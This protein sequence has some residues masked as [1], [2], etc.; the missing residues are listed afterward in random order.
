[1][2]DG[3]KYCSVTLRPTILF[4][5]MVRDCVCVLFQF[6]FDETALPQKSGIFQQTVERTTVGRGL[7]TCVKKTLWH[8]KTSGNITISTSR[9]TFCFLRTFSKV[10]TRHVK[11]TRTELF[12]HSITTEPQFAYVASV[13]LDLITDLDIYF[14]IESG[15]RG[16][17]SQRYARVNAPTLPNYCPYCHWWLCCQFAVDCYKIKR[18]VYFLFDTQSRT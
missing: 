4:Y 18:A 15:I 5:G 6:R 2:Y 9:Q 7:Q 14:M 16:G 12:A 17:V 8:K 11:R 1:M 10:S 3:F 13:E